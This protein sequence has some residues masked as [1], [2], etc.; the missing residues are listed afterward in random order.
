[1]AHVRPK[2]CP[3]N[4]SLTMVLVCLGRSHPFT[5]PQKQQQITTTILGWASEIFLG[6]G[7]QGG[8]GGNEG[9]VWC[10]SPPPPCAERGANGEFSPPSRS[11]TTSE[12]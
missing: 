6:E 9:R 8:V 11:L 5:T 3:P 4:P 10:R 1:M 7:G 12:R 2:K